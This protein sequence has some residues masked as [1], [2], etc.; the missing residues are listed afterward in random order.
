LE[1]P[2]PGV[3]NARVM[4]IRTRVDMLDS[5]IKVIEQIGREI[6]R[7]VREVPGMATAYS[8]RVTGGRCI[9]ICPNCVKP[10]GWILTSATSTNCSERREWPQRR[11]DGGGAGVLRT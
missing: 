4:P 5:G 2:F 3:T 11:P 9:E 7:A 1:A 6:K 8:E 10:P